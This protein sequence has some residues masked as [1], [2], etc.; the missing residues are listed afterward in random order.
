MSIHSRYKTSGVLIIKAAGGF[1]SSRGANH[2]QLDNFNLCNSA[3]AEYLA[4]GSNPQM[5]ICGGFVTHTYI[6]NYSRVEL[7]LGG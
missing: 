2:H 6:Q 1:A 5:S 3:A 7:A 4:V